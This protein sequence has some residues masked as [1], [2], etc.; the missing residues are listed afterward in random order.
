[1][2]DQ[3]NGAAEGTRTPACSL[4]SCRTTPILRPHFDEKFITRWLKCHKTRQPSSSA[5]C[6]VF[7]TFYLSLPAQ[8]A[9]TSP[10][11]I[12]FAA[13]QNWRPC[14]D[15]YRRAQISARLRNKRLPANDDA[16]DACPCR[17]LCA[18]SFSSRLVP[19]WV[20]EISQ[21][22]LAAA[23]ATSN[24]PFASVWPVFPRVSRVYTPSI[25]I[26]VK[27]LTD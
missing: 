24:N 21:V 10:P 9:W 25:A 19:V 15:R 1:M 23:S 27:L 7:T 11:E 22:P 8:P 4:A 6:L 14:R 18:F 13:A 20:S 5:E 2:G 17:V 16:F 12:S 26:G 3:K